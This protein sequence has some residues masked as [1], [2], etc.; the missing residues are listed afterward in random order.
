MTSFR[1]LHNRDL[2]NILVPVNFPNN[3]LSRAIG[4]CQ[5][6][7]KHY[8]RMTDISYYMQFIVA[9]N[10]ESAPFKLEKVNNYD[11]KSFIRAFVNRISDNFEEAES[12]LNE[13]EIFPQ[14][15]ECSS[16]K[17]LLRA[18]SKEEEPSKGEA[19]DEDVATPHHSLLSKLPQTNG[20]FSSESLEILTG[21]NLGENGSITVEQEE[22]L[23]RD[24]INYYLTKLGLKTLSK[25]TLETYPLYSLSTKGD[26]LLKV[27]LMDYFEDYYTHT[28]F[29]SNRSMQM[30]M[31]RLGFIEFLDV[32]WHIPGTFF[33][34]LYFLAYIQDN[35]DIKHELEVL[36]LGE[37]VLKEKALVIHFE[38]K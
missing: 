1:I 35:N 6:V 36:L 32:N 13:Y 27:N 20:P 12:F 31:A 17:A 37:R 34:A 15:I 28:Y 18:E 5:N 26:A 30:A 9:N 23:L 8:D 10:H 21:G 33:E 24:S 29:V 4:D 38:E 14:D 16:N 11:K 22:I 25:E 2:G 3:I 19:S 7:I